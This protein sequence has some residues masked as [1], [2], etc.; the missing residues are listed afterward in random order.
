M[1]EIIFSSF[2]RAILAF[3][4]LMLLARLMGKKLIS[5][6]TFFDFIVGVTIGS[7]TASGFV[8]TG[9]NSLI[10]GIVIL[11]TISFMTVLTGLMQL[12]SNP[13]KKLLSSEPIV[14][15]E[16]GKIVEENL[17]KERLNIPEL[18][19]LLRK[20]NIFNIADV[21]F[22]LLETDG[23]LSVLPKSQKQPVTPSD[24]NISST[25][26]GLTKD[27]IIDRE[28]M[29]ENLADAHLDE[30]WLG[31]QLRQ[32]G[33]NSPKEVFYAGLDTQGYLFVSMKRKREE[34]PGKYG[35]E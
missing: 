15:I 22:A 16:N 8:L 13:W 9:S 31:E 29:H 24:L 17:K 19:L 33:I 11:I 30:S 27:I 26:K 5:Q 2:L 23:S 32:R 28:V 6:M 3:I 7:V 25:Y 21:E 4:L 18:M 14:A 35:I 20:K 34:K 12:Q 10:S 1:N